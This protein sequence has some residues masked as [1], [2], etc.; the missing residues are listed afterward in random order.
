[1]RPLTGDEG[2]NSDGEVWVCWEG[3]CGLKGNDHSFELI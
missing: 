2:L 3:D 1:M